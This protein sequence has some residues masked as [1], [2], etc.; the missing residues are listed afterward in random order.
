MTMTIKMIMSMMTIVIM[1]MIMMMTT[2]AQKRLLSLIRP[3]SVPVKFAS[4]NP[5]FNISQIF[6]MF[7]HHELIQWNIFNFCKLFEA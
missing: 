7:I 2:L 1:I 4:I 3:C 5:H 6:A